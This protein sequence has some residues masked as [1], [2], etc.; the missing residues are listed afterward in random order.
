MMN[1]ASGEEKCSTQNLVNF[2]VWQFSTVATK[3]VK[4]TDMHQELLA[5]RKG[6]CCLSSW[7][8]ELASYILDL[9][10]CLY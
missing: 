3:A 6:W 5:R 1:A 10:D 7:I 9:S 2:A 4:A 8:S